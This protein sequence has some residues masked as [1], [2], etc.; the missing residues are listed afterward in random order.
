[1]AQAQRCETFRG[2]MDK[3]FQPPENEVLGP[4]DRIDL[5]VVSVPFVEPFGTSVASWAVKEA[6]LLRLEQDGLCGW[7]E[8]VADP[9]PYYDGE[10]TVTAAHLI[11]GVPAPS[12]QSHNRQNI[13]YSFSEIHSETT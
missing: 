6:L 12:A 5:I 7:G 11:D 4:I 13:R 2:W 3:N 9:D 10:T 1:M 8:C